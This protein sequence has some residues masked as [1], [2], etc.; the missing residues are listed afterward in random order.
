MMIKDDTPE[1]PIEE[2]FYGDIYP[3]P[4]HFSGNSLSLSL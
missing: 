1:I 4:Q 3:S 2:G